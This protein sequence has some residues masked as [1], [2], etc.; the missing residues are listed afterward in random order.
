MP[1]WHIDAV[2]EHLEAVSKGQIKRLLITIPPRHGK[3]LIVSVLWP[4]WEWASRPELRWLFASYAEALAIRDNVKARRLIQSA[5][6]RQHWGDV[7][8]LAADQ[9]EK[10]RV[11]NDHAGHRIAVGT[12]GSATG[13]GG[14]RLVIDDCHNVKE[15]ESDDVR[16]GVLDWHDQVWSTRANDP[17]TTARVIVGQRVHEDDIAGHVLEQ[18]G[19]EHLCLPTEF[20]G[21]KRATCIGWSDPRTEDGELLWPDRFGPDEVANDKRVLGSWAYA[22]QHQQHP[23]PGGGGVLKR[24]WWRFYRDMPEGL[25]DHLM[26]VD[27]AF[28]GASDSDWVVI[29]TWARRKADKYLLDQVR[30]RMDFPATLAAVRMMAEKWPQAMR[31]IIELKANGQALVDS[32]SREVEGF[33]GYSPK[34]SKEARCAAVS[35]EVE[36]GNVYLPDPDL[37]PWIK[38]FVYECSAF[39]KGRNDDQVDAAVQAL[40]H[41]AKSPRYA[42]IDYY[43]GQL[44]EAEAARIQRNEEA[45]LQVKIQAGQVPEQTDTTER[46]PRCG[47]TCL[48]FTSQL[49]RRCGGCG[50][51]WGSIPGAHSL[52]LP[53]RQSVMAQDRKW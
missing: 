34:E 4:T 20:E 36:S 32:L 38:D 22:A 53:N 43:E 5:W 52:R 25:T 29:Q 1:G 30:R 27:C 39:P 35:P 41:F 40:L 48:Q 11:E 19:W 6:Y 37:N 15:I 28:K 42:L 49:Q 14:D 23:T 47:G 46:C 10:R 44:K 50:A 3:S 33:V 31:K 13:E 12:G 18:G 17:K 21:D 8:Q 24:E 2:C 9:N 26:S 16:K 51:Q 45:M 7:Y